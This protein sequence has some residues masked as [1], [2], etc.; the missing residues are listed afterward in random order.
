MRHGVDEQHRVDRPRTRA[1]RGIGRRG[2]SLPQH[3]DDTASIE[4]RDGTER[5]EERHGKHDHECAQYTETLPSA[6]CEHGG[7]DATDAGDERRERCPA[8]L[9]R[10]DPGSDEEPEGRAEDGAGVA[11]S[12]RACAKDRA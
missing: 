2:P 4:E 3:T 8:I 9:R 11:R 10:D 5:Q 7:A 12:R 1:H 6:P